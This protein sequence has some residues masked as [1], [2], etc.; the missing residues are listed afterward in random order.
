MKQKF[1]CLE[2]ALMADGVSQYKLSSY[3]SD[4]I[5]MGQ[6][7]DRLVTVR[8]VFETTPNGKKWDAWI[9]RCDCG[10]FK[11]VRAANLLHGMSRSCGCILKDIGI[12]RRVYESHED[13]TRLRRI[14]GGMKYRCCNK[15]SQRY[16]S[17][18][19][20]GITVC[21]EWRSSFSSFYYWAMANG[22][23]EGLSIDRIDNDKGY[24]PENCRWTDAKTQI[25]NRSWCYCADWQGK[26]WT[27][28]ELSDQLGISRRSLFTT[29]H[30]TKYGI[31]V[32]K[33]YQKSEDQQ[34]RQ[35]YRHG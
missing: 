31:K 18:G 30:Q 34:P 20:R 5:I 11:I 8:R 23:K 16:Q 15:N 14:L 1:T 3:S 12:S 6:R 28:P 10:T 22:Y 33:R 27:L 24:Y 17:Y 7:F 2:D 21:Q 29:K 13:K 25:S 9:C 19:G 32:Y 35:E 26:R 4:A